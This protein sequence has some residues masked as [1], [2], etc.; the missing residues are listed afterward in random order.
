MSEG[1]LRA[2][3]DLRCLQDPH[4][5]DRGI[6]RHVESLLRRAV[7]HLGDRLRL[8]GLTDPGRGPVPDRIRALVPDIRTGFN[9]PLAGEQAIFVGLSPMTADPRS[10]FPFLGHPRV[11]AAAVVYDFIPLDVP[12][13]LTDRATE[14]RYR[15]RLLC[16]GLHDQFLAISHFSA[17]RL[18]EVCEVPEQRVAVT[19]AAVRAVFFES[20]GPAAAPG[21]SSASP[22]V[23]VVGGEDPRKNVALVVDAMARLRGAGGPEARLVIVGRY[24]AAARAELAPRGEAEFVECS[25]PELAAL[26]RGAAVT[27]AP[28]R[29]EGF[30]LPVVEAAGCGCPVLASDCDAHRELVQ[31]EDAL[32][33]PGDADALAAR[34]SRLLDD[35][36]IR[37]DLAARQAPMATPFRE[38]RVA[39]RFWAS[40]LDRTAGPRR[41]RGRP[42]AVAVLTPFPPLESGVAAF[43]RRTVDALRA[44]VPVDVYS[45]EDLRC[46]DVPLL[47]CGYDAV[48]SVLG[49]SR[50]H[51]AMFD[52]LE[53]YGGPVILHDA[54]LMYYYIARLGR[55]GFGR[56]AEE[57]I[58]R[59]VHAGE[60][61]AWIADE[62]SA[63]STFLHRVVRL[64]NPLIVHTRAMRERI[65]R[66][67]DARVEVIPPAPIEEFSDAD[68]SG[69]ARREARARLGVDGQAVL[70]ASFG[71]VHRDKGW[72]E[73]V[74]ALAR[75][76]ADGVP[77]ELHF[78]GPC[79]DAEDVRAMARR[80]GVA[81][82]VRVEARFRAHA[83]YRDFL[84]A[85]DV[86]IQLRTY[87]LGQYSAALTDCI[88]AGLPTVATEDLAAAAEAP[89][90]VVRV[91]D[92]LSA[93]RVA[94]GV[95]AALAER[96]GREAQAA[97]RATYLAGHG[98]P[99]YAARLLRLL[100]DARGMEP[101]GGTR[102]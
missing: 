44:L 42:G 37:R 28:S 50:D 9:V 68:L 11:H 17:R 41:R 35:R 47:P 36:S 30:S 21:R 45:G 16:L 78:V 65:E 59:P 95:R 31:G 98:F 19:G 26:Y 22:Y 96:G 77:A 73:C 80:G 20:G 85:A 7:T 89:D 24:S 62:R 56:F 8:I 57:A 94:D 101:P 60:I 100:R 74:D 84:R 91:P 75:L 64:A 93:D 79:V 55:D 82:H 40:V 53:A 69:P 58:G 81:D 97:A 5:A 6:G 61:D 99:A 87:R 27:V 34:L 10:T 13:Y 63:P 90:Y 48:I 49:N 32:F 23:L 38:D 15:S 66:E 71:I 43:S 12:G 33:D 4:Y 92:E 67:F 14:L 18:L 1:A 51:R 3:L 102:P 2:F 39:D 88:S 72:V 52:F 46:R 25:D 83:E 86:A 54:R 70:L 29:I 76:R